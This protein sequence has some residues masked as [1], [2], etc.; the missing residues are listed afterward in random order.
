MWKGSRTLF[1]DQD[2]STQWSILGCLSGSALFLHLIACFIYNT[3]WPMFI[4]L[5]Y[6]VVPVPMIILSESPSDYY[7]LRTEESSYENVALFLTAAL[8]SSFIGIPMVLLHNEMINT[9]AFWMSLFAEAIMIS[10]I[11]LFTTQEASITY[12]RTPNL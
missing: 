1:A 3:Y 5:A 7:F 2:E 8:G 9:G 6:A 11:F 10:A 4:F 12:Q